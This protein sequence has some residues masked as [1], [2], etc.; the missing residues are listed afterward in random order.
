MSPFL[1]FANSAPFSPSSSQRLPRTRS[2]GPS[3]P[4]RD[5]DVFSAPQLPCAF[6]VPFKLVPPP[7]SCP[8]NPPDLFSVSYTVLLTV[9]TVVVTSLSFTSSKAFFSFSTLNLKL[10][11]LVWACDVFISGSGKSL[12][13]WDK[14]SYIF[15]NSS[16]FCFAFSVSWVYSFSVFC[17]FIK[18]A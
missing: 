10:F 12:I 15:F 1:T 7:N 13:T 16:D 11:T 3:S 8:N 2:S 4:T 17:W 14:S 5:V 9:V 6:A 18:F